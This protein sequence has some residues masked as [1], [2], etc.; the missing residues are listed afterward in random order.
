MLRSLITK[1]TILTIAVIVTLI[2]LEGIARLIPLWPD[3]ISR[4]DPEL[5]FSHIPNSEGWWVNFAEP[6]VFRSY[7]HINSLGLHDRDF[8]LDKAVGTKRILIIGDSFVDA[9]EVPLENTFVKIIESRFMDSG[10]EIQVIN[11]GHYGYGTDQELLFY[12]LRGI[13]FQPDLVVLAFQPGNDIYDNLNT[14]TIGSKPYFEID[15]GNELLLKNFPVPAPK[16]PEFSSLSITKKI[17]KVLY[18]NSKLYRFSGSQIKMHSSFVQ[19]FLVAI[20]L[21]ELPNK[22]DL[23]STMAIENIKDAGLYK[24]ATDGRL[25][26]GWELTRRIILLLKTEVETSGARLIVVIMPDPQQFSIPANEPGWNVEKWNDRLMRL[27]ID[28]GLDCLDLYPIFRNLIME[29]R[30]K[31]YF[32]PRDGHL[33]PEGHLEVAEELYQFLSTRIPGN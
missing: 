28:V 30:N 27:C 13:H 21:M 32:F 25:E 7:V 22:E 14:G 19:N 5:G 16:E 4:F 24:A 3:S 2:F 29:D 23:G 10:D 11:G 17:K 20:G 33:T 8:D 18:D 9:L 12:R 6:F 26:H 15:P 31:T 1:L